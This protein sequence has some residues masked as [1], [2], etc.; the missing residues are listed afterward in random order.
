LILG[1]SFFIPHNISMPSVESLPI[2][3]RASGQLFSP[4]L[5]LW[6]ACAFALLSVSVATAADPASSRGYLS[7][8]SAADRFLQAWQ[9]SDAEA[10]MALLTNHAKQASTPEAMEAFFSNEPPSAYEIAHGKS[11]RPGRY[12]FPVTLITHAGGASGIHRQFSTIIVLNTG[13]NDWAVDKL[14]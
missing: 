5:C 7:A 14:P 2:L 13:N 11:L 8:L 12:E 4:I 10:G 9:S 1:V 3:R 6:V